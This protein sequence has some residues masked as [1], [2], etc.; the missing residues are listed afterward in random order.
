M[1]DY[2][3]ASCSKCGS[4]TKKICKEK[5]GAGLVIIIVPY[6]LVFGIYGSTIIWSFLFLST[7]LYWIISRPS[8]EIICNECSK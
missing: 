6:L 4:K 1:K 3:F 5:L 7:G 2:F 8:K